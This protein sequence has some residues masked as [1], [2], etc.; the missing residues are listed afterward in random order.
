MSKDDIVTARK[1]PDGIARSRYFID[2]HNPAGSKDVHQVAGAKGAVRS[3]FGP[4]PGDYYEVPYR[5]LVTTDC[6]NL[7]VACRALS[8]SHEAAAA[9][10]VM[11][12]MHAIGEAAGLA[13]AHAAARQVKL[14]ELS[15]AWVRA[16]IPYL[17]GPADFD[18][19]WNS[20]TLGPI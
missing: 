15:G 6:P 16:Q 13:A 3:D 8:A 4:P 12:T 10:R 14:C 7:A 17:D 11:A 18:P 9:V 2:I 20:L 5:S 19:V 1:F